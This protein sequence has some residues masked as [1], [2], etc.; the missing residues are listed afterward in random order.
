M[1]E[2][3]RPLG[4]A[5]KVLLP[6]SFLLACTANTDA[7]VQPKT[8]EATTVGTQADKIRGCEG[9]SSMPYTLAIDL[10]RDGK[11]FTMRGDERQNPS[12]TPIILGR[13]DGSRP[14][15]VK[16]AADACDESNARL[17]WSVTRLDTPADV[18]VAME[19]LELTARLAAIAGPR[20]APVSTALATHRTTGT[21][22]VR[23]ARDQEMV[24]ADPKWDDDH[25]QVRITRR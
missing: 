22:V 14:Y 20:P 7:P 5:I 8:V 11:T 23:L 16:V 13:G 10:T 15:I 12:G 17:R 4:S 3:M 2:P 6:A 18:E 1:H 21:T 25:I 24:L 9:P 19:D